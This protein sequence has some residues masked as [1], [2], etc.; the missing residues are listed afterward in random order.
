MP[1]RLNT[2]FALSLVAF[3]SLVA[4]VP[5]CG[6]VAESDGCY[7]D[8]SFNKSAPAVTF[9]TDV[10]PIFRASCAFVGAC[11]G[12]PTPPT[13]AQNY[14]GNPEI[15]GPMVQADIDKIFTQNVDVNSSK[16]GTM[17]IVAPNSP[18]MSF[19]MHKM[20]NTLTCADVACEAGCGGS[21]P[22][23][24]PI[25]PQDKRDT[26]RRWIAQGAKND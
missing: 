4:F 7:D 12:S 9:K 13:P 22:L 19:L 25:L 1:K 3:T 17:K 26:V 16:A 21:M 11:H 8:S 15:D 14:L 2:F 5:G 18:E 20:D 10:L 24:N 6:P 23:S